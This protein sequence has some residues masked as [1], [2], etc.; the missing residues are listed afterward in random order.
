MKKKFLCLAGI[1][2]AAGCM[3]GC[4]KKEV[5]PGDIA[6]FDQGEEYLSIWVHSIEDTEEGQAYKESVESFNEAYDGKYFADIEFIP[7]M[8]A[9]ADIPIRSMLPLWQEDCRM[10]LP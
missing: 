7:E 9:E 4:Q 6:G 2:L 1:L 5:S 3:S 8:T 10:Y